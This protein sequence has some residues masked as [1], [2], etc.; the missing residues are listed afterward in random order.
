[1]SN[2]DNVATI[3]EATE[4]RQKLTQEI[5][6]QFQ[7]AVKR[8]KAQEAK[9]VRILHIADVKHEVPEFYAILRSTGTETQSH[10]LRISK[11]LSCNY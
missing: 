1:M 5:T 10:V 4:L 8:I 2:F 11:D 9:K 7:E 6:M 3:A